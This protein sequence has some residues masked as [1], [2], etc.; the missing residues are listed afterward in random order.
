[1]IFLFRFKVGVSLLQAESLNLCESYG[2][3]EII[4][5]KNFREKIRTGNWLNMELH[6]PIGI[7]A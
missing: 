7:I 4:L 5:T 2:K 3:Q 1:M 6:G